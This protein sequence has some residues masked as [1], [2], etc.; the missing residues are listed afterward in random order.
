MISRNRVAILLLVLSAA[1]VG[2]DK[3]PL[4]APTESTI[5]LFAGSNT[6]QAN[7]STS[8]TATVLEKSGTPV[9]NGTLVSFTTTVGQISPSDARTNNGRVTV[10]LFGNGQSGE[11]E[12]RAT[13]GGAKPPADPLKIK[14]GGAA[15]SR[16][17][18]TA[19]PGTVPSNGGSSEIT[20]VVTDANGNPLASVQVNFS[21]TIGTLSDSA[22]T[23]DAAGQAKTTLTTNREATVTATAGAATTGTGGTAAPSQSVTVRVK[24]LPGLTIAPPTGAVT[25]G[26]PAS[27]TVTATTSTGATA[28]RDVTID[29][30]DGSSRSLGALAG[31]T[32]VPHTYNSPSTYT[33]TVRGVDSDGDSVPSVATAVV[34]GQLT[35][36]VNLTASNMAPTPTTSVLFT[37]LVTQSPTGT[38][39]IVR[40]EW[41]FGDGQTATTSGNVRSHI[42]STTP[43]NTTR[44][45]TVTAVSVEGNRGSNQIDIRVQ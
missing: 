31:S 10:T 12:V 22:A 5:A 18:L 19:N 30:G 23:T 29:F 17:Q 25:A 40:Y 24:V 36:S 38:P 2:C 9:Q 44:T 7:G 8:V 1:A 20:A 42:Y 37:A 15:A 3:V 13:S 4:L 27:F 33:V 34:V 28:F 41:D 6:V 43:V 32:S 16:I 11:A 14:V 35:L 39:N 45:V 26:T 21:T